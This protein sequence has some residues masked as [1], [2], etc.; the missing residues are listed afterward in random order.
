VYQYCRANPLKYID[1]RGS[2]PI[3]PGPG[4]DRQMEREAE[5]CR[6]DP[7]EQLII[8]GTVV[9]VA[10]GLM[11]APGATIRLLLT[12]VGLGAPSSAPGPQPLPLQPYGPDEP[13]GPDWPQPGDQD[14]SPDWDEPPSSP[15]D[16]F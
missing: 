11:V 14:F 6:Q 9:G 7:K 4:F 2:I 10:V 3:E 1:P 5:L 15:V 16:D 8:R 13:I 12:C